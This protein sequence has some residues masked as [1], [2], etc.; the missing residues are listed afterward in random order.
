MLSDETSSAIM[1]A[2]KMDRAEITRMLCPAATSE[3]GR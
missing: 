1:S 2:S 3:A